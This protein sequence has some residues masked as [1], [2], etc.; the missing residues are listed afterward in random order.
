M[1]KT[2]LNSN[3]K[4][5]LVFDTLKMCTSSFTGPFL[6]AYFIALTVSNISSFSVYKIVANIIAVAASFIVSRIIKKRNKVISFRIGIIVSILYLLCLVILKDS[7]IENS[8][9]LGILLGVSNG[10]YYMPYNYLV[11]NEVRDDVMNKWSG[12][13]ST[14]NNIIQIILPVILGALLMKY[15]YTDIAIIFV[16]LQV[17]SLIISFFYKSKSKRTASFSIRKFMNHVKENKMD[18]QFNRIYIIEFLNGFVVSNSALSS[19]ITIFVMLAFK[20]NINLG[21]F[22]S[23][24]TVLNIFIS[25]MI[26]K[27]GSKN[28]YSLYMITSTLLVVISLLLFT[29]NTN[30]ITLIIYNLFYNVAMV[31][32]SIITFR[33]TFY[34][35]NINAIKRNYQLE[36]LSVREGFLC[37]GRVFSFILLLMVGIYNEFYLYKLLLFVYSVGFILLAVYLKKY[38]KFEKKEYYEIPNEA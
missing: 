35:A 2:K 22:T 23:M 37:M 31:V 16:L 21:I 5:L 33:N 38:F 15:K 32:I 28:K 9:I 25:Y 13:K 30:N 7:V 29:Y 26:A 10:A 27:H 12:Y 36:Y 1:N 18:K 4:I 20:T 11:S 3:E 14:I 8:W 19:V 24:F 17:I 6:V 34:M